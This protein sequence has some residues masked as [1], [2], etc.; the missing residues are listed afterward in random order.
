MKKSSSLLLIT[1]LSSVLIAQGPEVTSWIVNVTGA[2]NPSYSFYES[3]V[4]SVDY[5]STDVYVSCTCIPG[6]DIGPWTANPNTPSN[7]NFCFTNL[8]LLLYIKNIT[9]SRKIVDCIKPEK[10]DQ[11]KSVGPE[12]STNKYK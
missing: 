11:I 10:Y 9:I 8:P 7:Q 1:L 4:Q 12:S 2:T 3:N 6:Y 5:N